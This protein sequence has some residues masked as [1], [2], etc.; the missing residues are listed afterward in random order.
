[1]ARFGRRTFRRFKVTTQTRR[2]NA[3]TGKA[4][5]IFLKKPTIAAAKIK[6]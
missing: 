5:R 3:L 6:R 4:A 2:G 1:M